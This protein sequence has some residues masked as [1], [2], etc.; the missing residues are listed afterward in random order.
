MVAEKHKLF[1]PFQNAGSGV[2]WAVTPRTPSN[3]W[4]KLARMAALCQMLQLSIISTSFGMLMSNYMVSQ[5]SAKYSR[6]SESYK[7]GS[8]PIRHPFVP[9]FYE[10]G[11]CCFPACIH[12]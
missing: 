7:R 9:R 5:W 4:T 2:G 3:L 1:F 12:S 8:G 10:S 6:F 11:F